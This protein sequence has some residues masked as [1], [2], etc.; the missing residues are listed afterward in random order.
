MF[1]CSQ[2]VF[3]LMLKLMKHRNVCKSAAQHSL[4]LYG[5]K[6]AEKKS[7]R[8][9]KKKKIVSLDLKRFAACAI[10]VKKVRFPF[11]DIIAQC[12]DSE[13]R[14]SGI[15]SLFSNQNHCQKNSKFSLLV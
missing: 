9:T 8:I 7:R 12:N 4:F 1:A 10:T 13:K 3:Q 14:V 11:Q 6:E 5:G 2:S 15:D